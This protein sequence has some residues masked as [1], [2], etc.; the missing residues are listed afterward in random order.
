MKPIIYNIPVAMVARYRGCR[1]IVRSDDPE[2]IVQALEQEKLDDLQYVQLLSPDVDPKALDILAHWEV[3]VPVDIIVSDPISEYHFL[4]NFSKLVNSRAVRVSIAARPGFFKVVKLALALHFAV[5]LDVGQPD[6]AIIGEMLE[7]LEL[8]LHR[9]TVSEPVE[10]FHSIFLSLYED[11]DKPVN[12][13]VIQEEDPEHFRFV[14][15]N[16][17]ETLSPRLAG[18]NL[19]AV[20]RNRAN[21]SSDGG[22]YSSHECLTCEFRAS[23]GGYFKWSDNSY[24]C[25]GVK[26]I[27]GTLSAAASALRE[28]VAASTAVFK[29]VRRL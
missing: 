18:I 7:A 28:D 10:Y 8:Y 20:N 24:D 13:W 9:D 5:K 17:I 27:F 1:V 11:E 2:Y 23:C 4:S 21:I 26:I 14:D 19:E 15:Y 16:G 12:L 25:T 6:S 22:L 3:G 29:R